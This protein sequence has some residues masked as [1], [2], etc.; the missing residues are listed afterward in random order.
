MWALSSGP[1]AMP[2]S[3]RQDPGLGGAATLCR[4]LFDVSRRSYRRKLP[5]T[6]ELST[7]IQRQPHV[8]QVSVVER[9]NDFCGLQLLLIGNADCLHGAAEVQRKIR[10]LCPALRRLEITI[11]LCVVQENSHNPGVLRSP[12]AYSL[13]NSPAFLIHSYSQGF[14]NTGRWSFLNRQFR[15]IATLEEE[16]Q[17]K[18]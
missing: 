17:P 8:V 11:R 12:Y 5:V 7:Q 4:R 10:V 16:M 15:Q 3:I 6:C 2:Q 14:H 1:D 9:E 18:R 13:P